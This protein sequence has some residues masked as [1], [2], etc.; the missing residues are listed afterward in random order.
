MD[1]SEGMEGDTLLGEDREEGVVGIVKKSGGEET[2]C[3]GDEHRRG[4]LR[5]LCRDE[6]VL[7][8]SGRMSHLSGR[9]GVNVDVVQIF[10]TPKELLPQRGEMKVGIGEKEECDLELRVCGAEMR[11]GGGQIRGRAG[12]VEGSGAAEERQII[13]LVQRGNGDFAGRENAG[14]QKKNHRN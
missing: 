10:I 2:T 14:S 1:K 8:N 6:T 7:K 11:E 5:L 3:G 4:P 12:G 9:I 13:G